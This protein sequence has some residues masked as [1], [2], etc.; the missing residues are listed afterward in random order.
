MQAPEGARP[1]PARSSAIPAGHVGPLQMAEGEEA[2]VTQHLAQ[3]LK[4]MLRANA[5][6]P[7]PA[8]SESIHTHASHAKRQQAI[9]AAPAAISPPTLTAATAGSTE[10]PVLHNTPCMGVSVPHPA[11]QGAPSATP[12]PGA[13]VDA[14]P[15]A[16]MAVAQSQQQPPVPGPLASTVATMTSSVSSLNRALLDGPSTTAPPS[17]PAAAAGVAEGTPVTAFSAETADTLRPPPRL[18]LTSPVAAS[19]PLPSPCPAPSCNPP[20]IENPPLTTAAGIPSPCMLPPAGASPAESVLFTAA[21][22][23]GAPKPRVPR[24]IQRGGKTINIKPRAAARTTRAASRMR[25]MRATAEGTPPPL[26]TAPPPPHSSQLLPQQSRAAGTEHALDAA[27]GATAARKR[28]TTAA[29]PSHPTCFAGGWDEGGGVVAVHIDDATACRSAASAAAAATE[30]GLTMAIGETTTSGNASAVPYVAPHMHVHTADAGTIQCLQSE[31]MT[32][33]L[34]EDAPVHITV[35]HGRALPPLIAPSPS[36][37]AAAAQVSP[38]DPPPSIPEPPSPPPA[39]P[40]PIPSP[41]T[42]TAASINWCRTRSV[43]TEPPTGPP[44]GDNVATGAAVMAQAAAPTAGGSMVF[45][46]AQH[47]PA[48]AA[49]GSPSPAPT[50]TAQAPL[51]RPRPSKPPL[52]PKRRSARSSRLPSRPQPKLTRRAAAQAAAAAAAST[53]TTTTDS[54]PEAQ[55]APHSAPR[56]REHSDQAAHTLAAARPRSFTPPVATLFNPACSQSR[57]AAAPA[58]PADG[59][60]PLAAPAAPASTARP[61]RT[62]APPPDVHTKSTTPPLPP[63]DRTPIVML[64]AHVAT[65]AVSAGDNTTHVRNAG[66]SAASSKQLM[67]SIA[68]EAVPPGTGQAAAAAVAGGGAS[69]MSVS[70]QDEGRGDERGPGGWEV[71]EKLMT[72][73][74]P[75]TLGPE[76]EVRRVMACCPCTCT[77]KSAR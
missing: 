30:A 37:A 28:P 50:V 3:Q 39:H 22:A 32:A 49:A 74:G 76:L 2:L 38:T 16:A 8:T 12:G 7:T 52:A 13:P 25:A 53:A 10:T 11:T 54:I 19:V 14:A 69:N 26:P 60:A 40:A 51:R 20:G 67:R 47:A 42:E 55:P 4:H 65:S 56:L 75:R 46:A 27:A 57:P 43:A 63:A 68:C 36:V 61:A 21:K 5:R 66:V 48:D 73:K 70:E 23:A 15:A 62:T 44:K 71:F 1:L 24:T 35:A 31:A 64:G 29:D 34:C 33:G 17:Q 72:A 59:I 9:T 58:A 41:V 77:R 45:T 6:P 18:P